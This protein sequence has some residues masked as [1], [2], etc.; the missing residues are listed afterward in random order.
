MAEELLDRHVELPAAGDGESAL[1]QVPAGGA[2]ALLADQN[3]QPLQLLCLKDLRQGLR[4][5]LQ[6]ETVSG[7]RVNWK[8]ITRHIRWRRVASSFEAD[9]IYLEAARQYFPATW[10]DLVPKSE[11]QF[12]HVDPE[13]QFPRYIRTSD[14][15]ERSGVLIGPLPDKQA[16]NRLIELLT[17]AFDLCRYHHILVQYPAGKA[18]AYKDM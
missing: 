6:E 5:R 11:A 3:N 18:C 10:R 9:W 13:E 4:H 12:V 15:T 7:R 14:F 2:V 1:R 17:D 8:E 16:A